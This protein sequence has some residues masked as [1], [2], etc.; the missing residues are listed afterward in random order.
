[1]QFHRAFL[2][3]CGRQRHKSYDGKN[4]EKVFDRND[5]FKKQSVPISTQSRKFEKNPKM[6]HLIG[7]SNITTG[8]DFWFEQLSKQLLM[9]LYCH[10]PVKKEKKSRCKLNQLDA[11]Q[12]LSCRTDR[13]HL[14][15]FPSNQPTGQSECPRS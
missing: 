13:R 2:L 8:K 6:L 9:S 10:L 12:C 5:Y 3:H 15:D 4:T 14:A 1:M 11:I 7:F